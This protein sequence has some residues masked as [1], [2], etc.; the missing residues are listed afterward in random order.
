ML[1]VL[2]IQNLRPGQLVQTFDEPLQDGEDGRCLQRDTLLVLV[3]ERPV[4]TVEV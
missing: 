1:G 2:E 4:E 3:I